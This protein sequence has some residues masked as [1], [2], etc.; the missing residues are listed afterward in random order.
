MES[1]YLP[2]KR[3]YSK[4]KEGK[5]VE[6]I[7]RED[8]IAHAEDKEYLL[9]VV[10]DKETAPFLEFAT[11]ALRDD[12]EIILTAVKKEGQALYYASEKLRDDREVVLE[13]V[14]NKGLIYKYA[15]KRLRADKELAIEA[16]HNDKR[17]Y[18][19]VVEELKEDESIKAAK[20][21][22]AE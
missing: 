1:K 15:S 21:G 17:A 10:A 19:Y 6:E 13:A 5:K 12:K 8:V 16:I 9:K 20:E 18:S 2:L 7:T 11:E 3:E 22:N 4:R 14:K